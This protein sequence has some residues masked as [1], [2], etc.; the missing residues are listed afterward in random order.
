MFGFIGALFSRGAQAKA[1]AERYRKMAERDLQWSPEE[2]AEMR[3]PL[4]V[5]G[6]WNRL[7]SEEVERMQKAQDER[8][9]RLERFRP[10]SGQAW[11]TE[12]MPARN[13]LEMG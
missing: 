4:G 12:R 2:I 7:R 3:I 13:M 6:E 10:T 8:R 5:Q 9:K 1:E 11:F